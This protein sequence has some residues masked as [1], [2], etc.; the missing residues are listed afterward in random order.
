MPGR[1]RAIARAFVRG[2]TG[3]SY[4]RPDPSLP[5]QNDNR[6]AAVWDNIQWT[7]G[8]TNGTHDGLNFNPNP[9]PSGHLDWHIV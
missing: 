4:K 5:D 2:L 3:R 8:T 9:N 1:N 6:P 7:P